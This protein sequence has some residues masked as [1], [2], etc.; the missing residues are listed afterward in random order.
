MA[1]RQIDIAHKLGISRIA[2]S[3][4]LRDHPDISTEMK[5]KVNE[6]ADELGYIPN[7]TA[8][9]LQAQKTNTIGVVVPDISNSFFSFVIHGIMDAA[10]AHGYQI[11]L[12]ASRESSDLQTQNIMT[13]LSMRVDGLLVA[14]SKDT[15]DAGIFEKAQK[16]KTPLVFFDRSLPSTT[17]SSVGIDD[18]EAAKR[19]TEFI[20]KQGHRRIAHLAGSLCTDIGVNRLQGFRD[21]MS[22]N[23]FSIDEDLILECGF[24][25]SDGYRMCRQSLQNN[26]IPDVIYAVND[27]TAQGA[28]Q[29][30]QEASLHIPK[31]ISVAAFGHQEFAQ[32]LHPQLTI[33]DSPPHLL[34]REALQLLLREIEKPGEP[35]Q[36]L[37]LET[38]LKVNESLRLL[39]H[40]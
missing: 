3:K 4:A 26:K 12:G 29:A 24:G 35:P 32:L 11:I 1:V 14:V 15:I 20:L 18:F 40:S 30:I 6:I 27:R 37:V 17:F 38:N 19:L 16:L 23:G 21:A 2:V 33:I 34:G 13:F 39:E 9:N 22:A 10:E 25:R 8:R 36:K 31:D 28:Y 7:F 5:K